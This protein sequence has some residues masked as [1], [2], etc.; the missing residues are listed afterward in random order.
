M[1][2]DFKKERNPMVINV[3][4][5]VFKNKNGESRVKDIPEHFS[6]VDEEQKHK[7][8]CGILKNVFGHARKKTSLVVPRFQNINL[9]GETVEYE[10]FYSYNDKMQKIYLRP[11]ALY[12]FQTN[13]AIL[14]KAV[15]TVWA[16]FLERINGTL[17]SLVSKIEKYDMRRGSLTHYYNMWRKLTDCC[18][19]CGT[20]LEKN[21]TDVD[22][23][24]P[25]SYIF[26][27]EAWNLVLACRSCNCKKSNHFPKRG[28]GFVIDLVNRNEKY[29][30]KIN[31]LK[32]SMIRNKTKADWR[33][34]IDHH[35]DI[36]ETYGF[37]Q[38]SMAV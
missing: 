23:F 34:E 9:D 31:E 5:D 14:S 32:L 7:A 27:N 28:D 4:N 18:F 10:I 2:Q 26:S 38:K 30:K 15:I 25:W 13:H 1:K 35:Y 3:M 8:K 11:E 36:S 22:H 24:I 6:M 37:S 16:K 29:R 21:Y 12:F 17:P 33:T 19:Y 20:T